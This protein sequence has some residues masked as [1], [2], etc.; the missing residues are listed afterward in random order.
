VSGRT[1]GGGNGMERIGWP[2]LHRLGRLVLVCALVLASAPALAGGLYVSEFATPDTG[3][4]NAGAIAR[5][6]DATTSVTNTAAMTRLDD[7]QLMLGFAPGFMVVEF[8][9]DPATPT[10]GND[11]GDQAGFLPILA[12]GYVHK[13]SDRV[14]LGLG[15]TSVSA[16]ILDPRGAWAGRFEMTE[17]S[18]ATL[19]VL[20]SVA[21]RVTDWLSVG[22]GAA[23][24][25]GHLDWKLRFDPPGPAG[26]QSFKVSDADD[27]ATAANVR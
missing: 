11:G 8:D 17:L 14:R 9:P 16:A 13:L 15:L 20:P 26:E 21:V 6:S 1:P 7:H 4:A 24:T 12:G 2:G 23:M 18:L 25:Y 10:G 3:T 5:G 22:L 27:F 19:T